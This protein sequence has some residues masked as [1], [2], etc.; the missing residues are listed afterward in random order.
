[1]MNIRHPN[2]VRRTISSGSLAEWPFRGGGRRIGQREWYIYIKIKIIIIS[3]GSWGVKW[4]CYLGVYVKKG[5]IEGYRGV[6]LLV[7]CGHV[8]IFKCAQFDPSFSTF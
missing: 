7:F 5:W 4:D 6:F 8:N 3:V 1:M 2:R